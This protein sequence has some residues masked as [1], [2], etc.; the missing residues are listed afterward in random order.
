MTMLNTALGSPTPTASI[1]QRR[2]LS[3]LA[4]QVT[5]KA[6]LSRVRVALPDWAAGKPEPISGYIPDVSAYELDNG[7]ERKAIWSMVT[8]QSLTAP[9]TE[10]RLKAFAKWMD[11][12]QGSFY[13]ALSASIEPFVWSWINIHNIPVTGFWILDA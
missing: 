10:P 8:W 12:E 4:T 9:S 3:D 1:T 7:H 2:F 6:N 11:E 5:N 13:L